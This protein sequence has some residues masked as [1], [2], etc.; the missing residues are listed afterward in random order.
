LAETNLALVGG[1]PH[2]VCAAKQQRFD[3]GDLQTL[4][5]PSTG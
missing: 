5:S 3:I 2:E 4:R 1:N